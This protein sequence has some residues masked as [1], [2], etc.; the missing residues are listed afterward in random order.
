MYKLYR[1]YRHTVKSRKQIVNVQDI[2]VERTYCGR[3]KNK[4]KANKAM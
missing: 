3:K 4:K 1:L 2:R